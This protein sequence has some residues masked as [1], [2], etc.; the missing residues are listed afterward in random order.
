MDNLRAAFTDADRGRSNKEQD[1]QGKPTRNVIVAIGK[2]AL[3]RTY[4]GLPFQKDER[5]K[6]RKKAKKE[7]KRSRA[8][9]TE[10]K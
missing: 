8:G 9:V 2:R 7:R 5:K 10:A 1:N 4:V 3:S 6:T